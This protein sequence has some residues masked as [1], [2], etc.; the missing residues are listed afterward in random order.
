MCYIKVAVAEW[1]SATFN[2]TKPQLIK[3][4]KYF[5]AFYT[6]NFADPGKKVHRFNT[7]EMD[8]E[9]LAYVVVYV[10]SG[11][12]ELNVD[13]SVLAK[14]GKTAAKLQTVLYEEEV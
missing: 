3:R 14:I 4:C 5:E 11:E 13:L 8:L 9:G 10:N 7:S 6:G 2:C 12:M 1:D